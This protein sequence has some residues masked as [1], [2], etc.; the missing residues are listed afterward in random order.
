MSLC[1]RGQLWPQS[2]PFR[3][4]SFRGPS[5]HEGS[6]HR[7]GN[8]KQCNIN[9]ETSLKHMPTSSRHIYNHSCPSIIASHTSHALRPRLKCIASPKIPPRP[10]YHSSTP[11]RGGRVKEEQATTRSQNGTGRPR[12]Q[13][14]SELQAETALAST[15]AAE[16]AEA[17]WRAKA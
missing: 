2:M 10:W 11:L 14:S 4:T 15:N 12:Y 16:S 1:P 3:P 6:V 7:C 17:R 5:G 8:A 13:I 9:P